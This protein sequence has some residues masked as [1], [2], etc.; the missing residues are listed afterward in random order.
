MVDTTFN[1]IHHDELTSQLSD[2]ERHYLAFQIRFFLP[3]NSAI[4]ITFLS[5]CGSVVRYVY[6][7]YLIDILLPQS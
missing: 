5:K 3:E 7:L 2:I 1:N 4:V 6:Y